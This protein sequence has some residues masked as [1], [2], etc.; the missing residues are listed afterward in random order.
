M[1]HPGLTIVYCSNAWGTTERGQV[2]RHLCVVLDL[3]QL[4]PAALSSSLPASAQQGLAANGAAKLQLHSGAHM[5]SLLRLRAE[6]RVA[7][8]AVLS[9]LA[10]CAGLA[11]AALG[12]DDLGS[13]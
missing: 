10:G 7:P 13:C 11:E 8:G 1:V 5:P 12:Q 2:S 4:A 3:E 9:G 6:T